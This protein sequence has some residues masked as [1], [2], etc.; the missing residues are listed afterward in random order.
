VRVN[1]DGCRNSIR[2]RKPGTTCS[3]S[4]MRKPEQSAL[5]QYA[6]SATAGSIKSATTATAAVA[7]AVDDADTDTTDSETAAVAVAV[8][9]AVDDQDDTLRGHAR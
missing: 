2:V 9:V 6:A 5:M 8:A 1:W 4:A 3:S 7:V